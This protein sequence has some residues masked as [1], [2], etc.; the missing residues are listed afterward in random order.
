MAL[1]TRS[2]ASI[3]DTRI[4]PF[5]GIQIYAGPDPDD[6]HLLIRTVVAGSTYTLSEVRKAGR[7][8]AFIINGSARVVYN[9]YNSPD[10]IKTFERM[11]FQKITDINILLE[12]HSGQP[13]GDSRT[14]SNK[15]ATVRNWRMSWEIPAQGDTK[16]PDMVITFRGVFSVDALKGFNE[17]Y[18]LDDT[19]RHFFS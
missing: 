2:K 15:R 14:I 6:L 1:V 4:F 3:T 11:S 19:E 17:A 7:V 9:D 12:P 13:G 10:F 5:H 8:V 18:D 16:L